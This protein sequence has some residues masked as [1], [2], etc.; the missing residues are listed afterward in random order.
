[1]IL[2]TR[3]R[4]QWVSD[5][6]PAPAARLPRAAASAAGAAGAGLLFVVARYGSVAFNDSSQQV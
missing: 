6:A 4:P 5:P 2:S 1:M 3:P